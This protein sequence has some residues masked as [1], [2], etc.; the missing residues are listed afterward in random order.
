MVGFLS[1]KGWEGGVVIACG[2]EPIGN[3]LGV[4]IGEVF[5]GNVVNEYVAKGGELV[6]EVGLYA[7]CMVFVECFFDDFG[8]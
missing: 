3:G 2:K 1:T 5:S 7:F 8:E 6:G 4:H